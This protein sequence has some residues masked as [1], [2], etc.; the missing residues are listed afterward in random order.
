MFA[1]LR[2]L[3]GVGRPG[4]RGEPAAAADDVGRASLRPG[5]AFLAA[6]KQ[7]RD[8]VAR[9][10]R[11]R[12]RR[13]PMPCYRSLADIA[14]EHRRRASDAPSAVTP[15]LLDAAFLVPPR[16]RAR[17]EHERARAG[18]QTVPGAGRR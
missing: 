7:A 16:R 15:P 3:R 14:A 5:A 6:Q 11:G 9:A 17:F 10:R 13:P 2:G 8:D 18:A 4:L 12:G 1:K